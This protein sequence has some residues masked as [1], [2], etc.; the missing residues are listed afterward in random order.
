[1]ELRQKSNLKSILDAK[2]V[3][4]FNMYFPNEFSCIEGL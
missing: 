4:V 3:G 1:M 2:M